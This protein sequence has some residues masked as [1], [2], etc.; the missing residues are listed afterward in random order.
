MQNSNTLVTIIIG[1]RSNLSFK[2]T[3]KI[4]NSEVY[5]ATSLSKSLFELRKFKGKKVN[6]IF[7]NFQPSNNLSSF[8]DPCKYI[9][10]S[11]SLTVRILMQ[12]IENGALINQIIY[13]S[14][15]SVYGNLIKTDKTD[16]YSKVA[17]IGIPASL[18]YLNEQFLTEVC[19]NYDLNLIITRI[20]NL[21]GGNDNF[22]IISKIINSYKN[23]STLN[24]RNGGKSLRDFI[25]INN[26]VDI[27]E[28]LLNNS[29][30][31]FDIID[32]GIGQAQSLEGILIYLSKNGYA[33]ETEN[34]TSFE[35]D[36]SQA[37]I[38]KI[39][40]IINVSSFMDVKLFLL[41]KLQRI[42][43]NNNN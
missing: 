38:S 43:V 22:S 17:P 23:K 25:H 13:T 16:D 7:N 36:F 8:V 3:K 28:K 33:I 12:L 2:L 19:K 26:V 40:K 35:I 31:K 42:N 15:S 5:S 1:E 32:I 24:V 9:E 39:Q 37:D 18:K 11:I 27:Y 21:Y 29:L 6:I 20:F 14:S 34:S 30:V 10:L 41:K 4:L